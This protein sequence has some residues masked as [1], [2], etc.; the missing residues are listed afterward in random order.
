MFSKATQRILKQYNLTPQELSFCTMYLSMFNLA[1]S[2]LLS[3]QPMTNKVTNIMTK[4]K[5]LSEQPNIKSYIAEH[6]GVIT[7][8]T[9][10][11]DITDI[12][13][14]ESNEIGEAVSIPDKSQM[15][16]SLT[17]LIQ[18]TTDA[19]LKSDLIMKLADLTGVR[20]EQTETDDNKINYYLPITCTICPKNK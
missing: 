13:D 18:K 12:E 14:L 5:R 7:P 8:I 3:F 19:K 9:Q 16:K 11:T 20:R 1:D 2:Y 6:N 10:I 15:I 17:I 4:A